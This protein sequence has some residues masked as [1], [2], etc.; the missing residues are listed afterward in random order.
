MVIYLAYYSWLPVRVLEKQALLYSPGFKFSLADMCNT[1]KA[2]RLHCFRSISYTH[3]ACFNK[4]KQLKAR[5]E[6]LCK[7][8]FIIFVLQIRWGWN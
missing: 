2:G 8:F 1:L 3:N 5:G 6:A 7:Y 4:K